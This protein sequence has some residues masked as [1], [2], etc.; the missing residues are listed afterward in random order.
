MARSGTLVVAALVA[1]VALGLPSPVGPPP[2]DAARPARVAAI[3]PGSVNR[4]SLDLDATYRATLK[5]T[6]ATRAIWV[7]ST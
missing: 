7:D 1:V 2:I 4:S 6:W 5:L 3:V